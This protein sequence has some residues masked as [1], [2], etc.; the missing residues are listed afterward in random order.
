MVS[1]VD[2]ITNSLTRIQTAKTN[3]KAAIES[4]GVSVGNGLIDTYADKIREIEDNFSFI[5]QNGTRAAGLFQGMSELKK[6]PDKCA[7]KQPT[8]FENM[9][10]DCT[11]LEEAPELD[12][13]EGTNFHGM[14]RNTKGI[15]E[16]PAYNTSKG[17]DFSDM[18]R[19]SK[20]ETPPNIDTSK[21]QSFYRMFAS[22]NYL[23]SL[24]KL[25]TTETKNFGYMFNYCRRMVNEEEVVYEAGKCQNFSFM[26]NYCES[27]RVAPIMN[28][29][30]GRVFAYMFYNCS[31]L[32]TIP[33]LYL[34]NTVEQYY[35]ENNMETYTCFYNAFSGCTN[36]ENIT[37]QGTIWHNISFYGCNKLTHESLMS[38]I[39]AL[40]HFSSSS[41]VYRYCQLGSANLAKLTD[42]EK[43]I[44]TN[45]GWTLY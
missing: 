15:K 13:S 42:E 34:T 22:A 18:F 17:T 23:A 3:I 44:A 21:G 33:K 14:F 32:V 16:V 43:A 5:S 28:T 10:K 30:N 27:M 8:S 19:G 25:D 29:W 41:K 11:V 26:F 2:S 20:I 6:V 40:A 4:K 36:L 9:F 12:T 45:K 24:P 37:I 31:S 1:L 38:I 35:D 39:N 7:L